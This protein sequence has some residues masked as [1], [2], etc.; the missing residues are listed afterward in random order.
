MADFVGVDEPDVEEL[1]EVG[2]GRAVEAPSSLPPLPTSRVE[3]SGSST[4]FPPHAI[5]IEMTAQ[6]EAMKR[7]RAIFRY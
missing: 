7:R 4:I 5:E 3:P 6:I 1:D 2:T